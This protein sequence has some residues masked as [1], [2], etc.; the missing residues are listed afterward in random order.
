MCED[1]DHGIMIAPLPPNTFRKQVDFYDYLHVQFV[2]KSSNLLSLWYIL[3]KCDLRILIAAVTVKCWR[4]LKKFGDMHFNFQINRLITTKV[5]SSS[6]FPILP[7]SPSPFTTPLPHPLSPP[8]FSTPLPHPA[9]P[10]RF[11]TPLPHPPF[12]TPPSPPP[13]LTPLPHLPSPP[14]SPPSF[15]TPFPTPLPHTPFPPPSLPPLPNP[16]FPPP[17]PIYT[18]YT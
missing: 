8:R 10:P 14:S 11:S 9:S 1:L 17:F 4:L 12:L 7:P 18:I 5:L 6:T 2:K 13:F 15:P 16:P 3:L